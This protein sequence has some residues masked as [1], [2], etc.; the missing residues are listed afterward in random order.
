MSLVGILTGSEEYSRGARSFKIIRF[1]CIS[2]GIRLVLH[3]MNLS[4]ELVHCRFTFFLRRKLINSQLSS[5][6]NSQ[7]TLRN[8]STSW[9]FLH[10]FPEK[11]F[12][13]LILQIAISFP[14]ELDQTVDSPDGV[15]SPVTK[16]NI[17]IHLSQSL[18]TNSA[19]ASDTILGA[20]KYPRKVRSASFSKEFMKSSPL[21]QISFLFHWRKLHTLHFSISSTFRH[22][23]VKQHIGMVSLCLRTHLCP[24]WASPHLNVPAR[25][26][27]H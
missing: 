26:G 1:S 21:R 16:S 10:H 19:C 6:L 4:Q 2:Q 14:F 22:L 11:C 17:S 9:Q 8:S 5:S 12:S 7:Q 24:A 23:R 20:A 27:W 25:M 15:P 13:W 3:V 18:L